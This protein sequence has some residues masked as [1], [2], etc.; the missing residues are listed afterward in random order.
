MDYT[1]NFGAVFRGLD[2]L[3]AGL[4]LG[5]EMGLAGLR[6]RLDHRRLRGARRGLWRPPGAHPGRRLCRPDPQRP[7]PGAGALRLL[8]AARYR[9]PLLQRRDL[10]RGARDLCRGLSDRIRSAPRSSS[11]RAASP[12]PRASIGLTRTGTAIWVILPDRAPE[13]AAERRQQ[14]HL[15]VQGHLDRRGDRGARAHLSGAEDQQ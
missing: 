3:F 5:L 9:H 8:R 6:R 10:R 4:L 13:R 7:D 12:R 14:F 1:L 2:D 11:S 15:A